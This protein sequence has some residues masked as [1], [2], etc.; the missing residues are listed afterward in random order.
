M[1]RVVLSSITH[2]L[3]TSALY[4]CT[5][6]IKHLFEC[7]ALFVWPYSYGPIRMALF[8]WPYSYGPIRIALSEQSETAPTKPTF[9]YAQKN[10]ARRPGFSKSDTFLIYFTNILTS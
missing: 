5:K 4:L 2:Q 7:L 3:K 1:K 8:V 10:R 6:I 9:P